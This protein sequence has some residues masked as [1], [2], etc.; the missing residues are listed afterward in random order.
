MSDGPP[1]VACKP[2]WFSQGYLGQM[3][4]GYH[5]YDWFYN[6]PPSLTGGYGGRN[7]GGV[8]ALVPSLGR[9]G[10]SSSAPN[11]GIKSVILALQK[12]HSLNREY[13]VRQISVGRWLRSP[14][15]PLPTYRYSSSSAYYRTI[16]LIEITSPFY[17]C[18]LGIAG[19][20]PAL[21]SFPQGPHAPFYLTSRCLAPR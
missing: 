21:L 5:G 16:P 1:T 2:W 14:P 13:H 15:S 17:L 10:R 7:T 18:L 6:I 4:P 19:L 20:P 9:R 3:M 11:E 12:K 8:K